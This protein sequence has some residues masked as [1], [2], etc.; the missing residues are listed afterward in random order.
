MENQFMSLTQI[1]FCYCPITF[2]MFGLHA[3]LE[4]ELNQE[5]IVKCC[6]GKGGFFPSLCVL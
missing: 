5:N 1:K 3:V 4:W 2:Y 6:S